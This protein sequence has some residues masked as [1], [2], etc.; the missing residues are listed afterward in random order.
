MLDVNWTGSSYFPLHSA[1]VRC[2]C[3][4][5]FFYILHSYAAAAHNLVQCAWKCSSIVCLC[6][7]CCCFSSLNDIKKWKPK[8]KHT[9]RRV[10]HSRL[11]TNTHAHADTHT[12]TVNCQ[13]WILLILSVK[14]EFSNCMWNHQTQC[15]CVLIPIRRYGNCICF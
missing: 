14:I 15:D 3:V 2:C 10:S 4:V 8:D 7:C 5:L 13:H 9:M 12:H 1:L 11:N 6:C